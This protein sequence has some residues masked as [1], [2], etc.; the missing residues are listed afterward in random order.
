LSVS[1]FVAVLPPRSGVRVG[2]ESEGSYCLVFQ[3][4]SSETKKKK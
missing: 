3:F 1:L 4:F 2:W